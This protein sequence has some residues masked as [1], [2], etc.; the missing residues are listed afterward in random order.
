[1][2]TNRT[3]YAFEIGVN[4]F[5][6]QAI[7]HAGVGNRIYCPCLKC[8]NK[9]LYN[10]HEVKGNI[11]FNGFDTNYQRW[12][13]HGESSSSSTVKNFGVTTVRVPPL[14]QED[15]DGDDIFGMMQDV[16]EEFVDR[17]DQ[18]EKLLSDAEKPLY[19]GCPNN[20]T[21]LSAIVRLYNLKAANGWSDKS[22][23]DLLVAISDMLPQPNELY[24]SMYQVKKTMSSL[25]MGYEKIHACRNDCVLY[26]KEHKDL[27]CCLVCGVSRWKLEKNKDTNKK[28]VPA[29]VIW[30]IPLIPRF[31]RLFRNNTHAKNLTWLA[32]GRIKDGM[33]RHP[34]DAPQWKTIDIL[35]PEFGKDSRN[36]RLGLAA[37]GMNPHSNQSTSYSTWPVILVNYNLPPHLC[38]KRKFVMLTMLISGPKQP[39]NDIDVF[40]APLVED[41]K[42]CVK[43]ELNVLMVIEMK[44]LI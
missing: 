25:G 35:Y 36:L 21:K 3:T 13:W 1:M 9:A 44:H 5:L 29:K 39:G 16:E 18:F 6:R 30:Y 15:D 28:S 34:A 8:G 40:L 20:Y 37:D 31:R 11:F 7:A 14:V 22:F 24:T 32:T 43:K 17:P 19:D 2:F 38:M 10:V 12:I 23:S 42:F 41:L 26:R 33:L 27:E 4:D